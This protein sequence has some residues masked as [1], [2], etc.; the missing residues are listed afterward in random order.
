[1]IG[2][3]TRVLSVLAL[4]L[5]AAACSADGGTLGAS[6]STPPPSGGPDG[7][8]TPPTP[9]G[10]P[11]TPP[12]GVPGMGEPCDQIDNDGDGLVDEACGCNLGET[13]PCWLGTAT[14][15]KTGACRD[16]SQLCVEAGEFYTWGPCI[17]AILPS[18]EVAADGIDQDCDGY[19]EGG[20][21]CLGSEFGEQC[22]DGLDEDCDGLVDCADTDCACSTCVPA[23]AGEF[24]EN[25][26]DDDCDGNIDCAD[27]DCSAACAPPSMPGCV[28]DFPFFVEVFCG[29]GRDNDC[30]GHIDCDDSDCRMPGQCF[31]AHRETCGDGVDDDCDRTVDCED[32]DC[33]R[34]VPGATRWCD[35]PVY[36]H[37]G[38]QDCL[39][40]G[41]WGACVETPERP[42][43][44]TSTI[45]SASCCV[46]AGE[47]CQ[48]YPVDNTSIGD[49]PGIEVCE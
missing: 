49:C 45:Y 17:G 29:D 9:P 47:C 30:D 16:G 44:C 34:C 19:D 38:R 41:S 33:R 2:S 46:E 25:G 42:A 22:S 28:P 37:W 14:R 31:C 32:D 11:P 12:P 10:T 23:P 15:R 4:A 20:G 48:N 6:S 36:C 8:V 18:A 40:D 1:M 3:R 26:G 21:A 7:S 5:V 13:Q 35:D 24:C 39:P 27:P 43:G